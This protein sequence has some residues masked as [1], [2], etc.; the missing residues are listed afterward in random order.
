MVLIHITVNFI[1]PQLWHFTS[2][3]DTSTPHFRHTQFLL[4]RDS[5]SDP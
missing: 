5:S 1:A 3:Y 4:N 2:L